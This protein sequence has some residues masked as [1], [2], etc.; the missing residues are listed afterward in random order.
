MLALRAGVSAPTIRRVEAGYIPTPHVQ[1]AIAQVFDR[2][3]TDL[4]PLEQQIRVAA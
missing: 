4:W 1:F 2:V 3:P